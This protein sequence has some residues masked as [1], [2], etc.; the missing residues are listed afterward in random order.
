MNKI[1]KNHY[2]MIKRFSGT[3]KRNAP[4]MAKKRKTPC[5]YNNLQP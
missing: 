5:V 1:K 3:V 2:P 4:K